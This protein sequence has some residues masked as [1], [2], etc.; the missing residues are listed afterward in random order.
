MSISFRG[1]S[2]ASA[3]EVVR[4]IVSEC[5]DAGIGIEKIELDADLHRHMIGQRGHTNAVPREAS[6]DL[7]GDIRIF[8]E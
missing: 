4:A 1:Q 2:L 5:A 3:A 8:A 7:I 6:D